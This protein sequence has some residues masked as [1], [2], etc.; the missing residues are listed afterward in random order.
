MRVVVTGAT[1]FIG[2]AVVR[3]LQRDGTD[4]V[5]LVRDV[6]RARSLLGPDVRCVEESGLAAAI[7]GSDG[8]V[9]LAGEPMMPARWTQTRSGSDSGPER[10]GRLLLSPG[11]DWL[12]VWEY[13]LD[14]RHLLA[15]FLC[16][17][18]AV[19]GVPPVASAGVV[20]CHCGPSCHMQP[21]D[22]ACCRDQGGGDHGTVTAPRA[23]ETAPVAVLETV[24]PSVPA[25]IPVR[26][27]TDVAPR[28]VS[29]NEQARPPPPPRFLRFRT[30]LR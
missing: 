15:A 24:A 7:D 1:G 5:A 20:T 11:L 2:R 27:A 3:R 6:A 16:F 10:R 18:I 13:S 9:N 25:G 14:V 30:L 12:F 19:F 17:A 4:I 26:A 29:T 8:V 22:T 28:V 23:P 21:G